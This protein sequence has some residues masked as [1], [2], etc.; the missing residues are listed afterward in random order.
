MVF[1]NIAL[2]VDLHNVVQ[3]AEELA[4]CG[5]APRIKLVDTF[6]IHRDTNSAS[7]GVNT[8]WGLQKMVPMF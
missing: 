5:H 8:E 4:N 7:F 3:L 2:P 6:R 1:R